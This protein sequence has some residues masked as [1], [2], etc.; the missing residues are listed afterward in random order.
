MSDLDL[1]QQELPLPEPVAVEPPAPSRLLR[2]M[3]FARNLMR[4]HLDKSTWRIRLVAGGFALLYC[5][6]GGKL[7]YLAL[8]PDPQTLRRAASEAVRADHAR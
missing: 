5:V 2:A 3:L 6:I 8:K 4:T 7:V 1:N